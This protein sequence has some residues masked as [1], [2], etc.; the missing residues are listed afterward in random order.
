M[1]KAAEYKFEDNE[2]YVSIKYKP[3]KLVSE[4]SI[5]IKFFD[6]AISGQIEDNTPFVHGKL[7][8]KINVEESFWE[9]EKKGTINITC[10]K[11]TETK[12]ECPIID[13]YHEFLDAHSS[14]LISQYF[15]NQK[16]YKAALPFLDQAAKKNHYTANYQ[17]GS[18]YYFEEM[19]WE[20]QI[21]EK[22]A[23]KYLKVAV[24][25]GN[26]QS[27]Y[28]IGISYQKGYGCEIN[29]RTAL[30]YYKR[31]LELKCFD[32]YNPMG[33][34]YYKGG[35]GIE[36]DFKIAFDYFKLA[37]QHSSVDAMIQLGKMYIFGKG[38][39][40][41]FDQAQKYFTQATEINPSVKID[42]HI[43]IILQRGQKEYENDLE[44][45][46]IQDDIDSDSEQH[47]FSIYD[48]DDD[49]DDDDDEDDDEEDVGDENI[50]IE[51][52][53]YPEKEG[54]ETEENDQNIDENND[55]SYSDDNEYS[56]DDIQVNSKTKSIP[57]NIEKKN[58]NKNENNKTDN[59]KIFILAGVGAGILAGIGIAY[60]FY[61]RNKKKEEEN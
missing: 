61:D 56:S 48:D 42:N 55:S 34:I 16:N 18:I 52:E 19:G 7:F 54:K 14:Y 47:I 3:D 39:E 31:A 37:S 11:D 22:K 6:T 51:E 15:A 49:D 30:E 21:N 17:L 44:N 40:R 26:G 13:T 8:D 35:Y 2:G 20:V 29:Y 41:N 38:T 4:E 33:E 50:I 36:Q 32:V 9:L 46:Y 24:E 59:K 10:F 5:N 53:I 23:L 25:L 57:E 58:E 1:K 28:L 27:A 43:L 60:Y 12:W 45:D